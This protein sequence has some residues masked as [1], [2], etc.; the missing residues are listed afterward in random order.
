MHAVLV[1]AVLVPILSLGTLKG[2]Q[3]LWAKVIVPAT[4]NLFVAAVNE[5]V[6]PSLDALAA[7]LDTVQEENR[8]DHASVVES[9]DAL[10]VRVGQVEHR[11][12]AVEI[13][14]ATLH[15]SDQ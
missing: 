3:W 6:Q 9:V 14:V 7:K 5:T 13:G 12:G 15:P 2:V 11:L 4:H 1:A 10:E 8:R